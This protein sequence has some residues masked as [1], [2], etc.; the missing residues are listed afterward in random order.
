VIPHKADVLYLGLHLDR[1]LTW[2]KHIFAKRKQL[3]RSQTQATEFAV[4][5]CIS[6]FRQKPSYWHCPGTEPLCPLTLGQLA[7]IA[8]ERWGH[9]VAVKSLYQGC[10][11]TF[12]QVKDEVRAEVTRVTLSRLLRNWLMFAI[13]TATVRATCNKTSH[14]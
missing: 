6:N 3:A 4:F 11:L 7:D 2:H 14:L 10:S 8:A 12:R 9:K 13:M 1:R 5:I